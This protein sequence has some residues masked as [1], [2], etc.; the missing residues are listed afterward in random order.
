[1]THSHCPMPDKSAFQPSSRRGM[2]GGMDEPDK[3]LKRDAISLMAGV[4]VC[5][6]AAILLY[7]HW[8]ILALIIGV[9]LVGGLI[10]GFFGSS[11]DERPFNA[12]S[13]PAEPPANSN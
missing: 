10:A 6:F 1:M 5:I 9:S 3:T 4:G 13:Q 2:I 7:W 8:W 11:R 12:P